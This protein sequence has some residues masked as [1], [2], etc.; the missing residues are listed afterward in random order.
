[1]VG[2]TFVAAKSDQAEQPISP[3]PQFM[4]G[5]AAEIIPGSSANQKGNLTSLLARSKPVHKLWHDKRG[6]QARSNFR[7]K[8]DAD[9]LP[10]KYWTTSH[11]STIL[12][13][14]SSGIGGITNKQY[15]CTVSTVQ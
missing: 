1:M 5:T 9:M 3:P 12:I 13:D 15:Y 2:L 10:G 7:F 14:D 11:G 4:S 8:V 6:A